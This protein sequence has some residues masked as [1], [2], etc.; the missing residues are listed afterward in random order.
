MKKFRALHLTLLIILSIVCF[1][2]AAADQIALN[3][4]LAPLPNVSWFSAQVCDSCVSTRSFKLNTSDW[5]G[6]FKNKSFSQMKES[7]AREA[8]SV[9]AEVDENNHFVA[10]VNS[11]NRRINLQLVVLGFELDSFIDPTDH[12]EK[13]LQE[14]FVLAY[15]TE[16]VPNHLRWS[17]N[18][19][20]KEQSKNSHL[21]IA[22][23]L[24]EP[25]RLNSRQVLGGWIAF[26]MPI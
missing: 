21:R 23:W 4:Q 3:D 7:S 8:L 13:T 10:S 25:T 1:D 14:Q 26:Q 20:K 16:M 22:L 2:F 17:L 15:H 9:G 18:T 19:K 6:W 24:N 12:R 5:Q 11:E